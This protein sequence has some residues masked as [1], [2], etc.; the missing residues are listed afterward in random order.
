MTNRLRLYT[1][2]AI[3]ILLA[4]VLILGL[5]ILRKIQLEKS[6]QEF[7]IAVTQSI[8][9]GNSSALIDNSVRSPLQKQRAEDLTQYIEFAARTLGAVE[10]IENIT[11]RS[12]VPLLVFSPQ[13]PVA[14]YL[15]NVQFTEESAQVEIMLLHQEGNWFISEFRIQAS[16]LMD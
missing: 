12:D 5:G 3:L 6:G 10:L 8:L 14:S 15:I 4:L 13:A 1:N 11:G 16:K 7:A 2:S 9:A